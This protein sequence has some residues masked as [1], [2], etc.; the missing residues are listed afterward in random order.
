LSTPTLEVEEHVSRGTK[1]EFT[2]RT[3]YFYTLELQQIPK[4]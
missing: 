4:H 1:S 3:C 2:Q